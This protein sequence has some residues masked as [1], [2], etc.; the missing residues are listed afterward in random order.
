MLLHY[1]IAKAND[2]GVHQRTTFTEADCMDTFRVYGRIPPAALLTQPSFE[3]TD[4]VHADFTVLG[5]SWP[6]SE[7]MLVSDAFFAFDTVDGQTIPLEGLYAGTTMTTCW[8]K[9][10]DMWASVS[11]AA[12][13]H[14]ALQP[15]VE[16]M[17][18]RPAAWGMAEYCGR[19]R[20]MSD[21]PDWYTGERCT[22]LPHNAY[23]AP[24]VLEFMSTGLVT[25][26]QRSPCVVFLRV[27]TATMAMVKAVVLQCIGRPH[28]IQ[29]YPEAKRLA[30]MPMES[31]TVLTNAEG[32][33]VVPCSVYP[34]TCV[35][36][37]S[38]V[39][40]SA[41]LLSTMMRPVDVCR[42]HTIF[43]ALPSTVPFSRQVLCRSCR[44]AFAGRYARDAMWSIDTG[45]PG[46]R[47]VEV[48]FVYY[49]VLKVN[50]FDGLVN[51]LDGLHCSLRRS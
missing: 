28:L 34:T 48:T 43:S 17:V 25:R 16:P 49:A 46:E 32:I 41:T 20:A 19:S 23:R 22:R 12:A 14:G 29:V 26:T 31:V 30:H 18:L 7:W 11:A 3:V 13:L 42:G 6:L 44:A 47:M 24:F 51:P 27:P 15:D 45:A 1:V 9:E 37:N 35:I 40:V 33:A 10:D 2:E 39:A 5:F 21:V 4:D 36:V 50:D 8:G 38:P